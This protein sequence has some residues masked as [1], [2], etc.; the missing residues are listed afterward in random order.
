MEHMNAIS[1]VGKF[2]RLMVNNI[3]CISDK[4]ESIPAVNS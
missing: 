2:S 3:D 1:S 4:V